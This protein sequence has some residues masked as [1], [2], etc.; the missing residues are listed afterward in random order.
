MNA[1]PTL[2]SARD[3]AAIESLLAF[4][5][6][7]GVEA[8]FEE[9][10]QD[11]TIVVAPALKAVAKATASVLAPVDTRDVVAEARALARS[12]DT[13][14][15]LAQAVATF[16]GCD[17]VGLGARGC[18]FG[19]G[20]TNATLLVIGHAPAAEDERSG[21]PF[22]GRT[23]ALTDRMLAAIAATGRTYLTNTVFWRPPG[24]RAPTPQEQAACAPFL[25]R[26]L[27]LLKP[28]AVL[29]LGAVAAGGVLKS[30]ENIV[31]ARGQW[32]E[33]RLAE[34]DVSA[35]AL[36]TFHPAFLI[37][38]PQAKRQAWADL[39]ALAT[40]LDDSGA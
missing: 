12:A 30:D 16:R 13:V 1:P 4:W 32:R 2:S 24:D 3:I 40:R 7:A 37:K 26:L 20:A 9:A 17:L 22:S 28:R 23:G 18:V 35:P 10:P 11:R 31:K 25:D 38:Q 19:R 34:G 6:D 21:E 8:C 14:E 33:W 27:E 36:A 39:L 15:A 29:L 5:R